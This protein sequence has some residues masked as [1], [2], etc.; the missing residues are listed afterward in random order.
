VLEQINEI[1]LS[2]ATYQSSLQAEIRTFREVSGRRTAQLYNQSLDIIE[3]SVKQ[4]SADDD[5]IRAKLNAETQG[6]CIT[7]LNNYADSIIELSGYAISA[8]IE[9]DESL[10]LNMTA[11][12]TAMLD[13]FEREVNFLGE[14]ALNALI[15]RNVFTQGDEII[16]R[17][18][19]QLDAKTA[20]FNAKRGELIEKANQFPGVSSQYF[21]TLT[22]CA[23]AAFES[24]CAGTAFVESQFKVCAR[25]GSR[26]TRSVL[27]NPEIFFPQ[28]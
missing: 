13:S 19:E 23:N 1:K 22:S 20:A 5:T 25:F 26:G 15:G 9:G 27:P 12:F 6:A 17:V 28:L 24:V 8:C 14:I 16:A 3:N 18:Q 10:A 2:I 4:I 21:S 11:E 7:N